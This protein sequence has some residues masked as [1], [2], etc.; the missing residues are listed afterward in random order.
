MP[1]MTMLSLYYCYITYSL[2]APQPSPAI[3]LSAKSSLPPSVSASLLLVLWERRNA[4]SVVWNEVETM[5]VGSDF[6]R[7]S[8]NSA[9]FL[10]LDPQAVVV[11]V[12]LEPVV[13]MVA[14]G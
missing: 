10:Y 14:F 4:Y 7:S 5:D 13:A 11:K 12:P 6:V 3:L 1:G 2:P 9:C 8:D